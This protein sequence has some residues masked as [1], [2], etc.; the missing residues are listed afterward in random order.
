MLGPRTQEDIEACVCLYGFHKPG[1]SEPAVP[2]DGNFT[3]PVAT[4]DNEPD[5]LKASFGGSNCLKHH[6]F[7]IDAPIDGKNFGRRRQPCGESRSIPDN[8][9]DLSTLPDRQ[10]NRKAEV[11][12]AGTP[13][14]VS[15]ERS[16]FLCI[17]ESI[18]TLFN[19]LKRG[20]CGPL[21]RPAREQASP[22]ERSQSVQRLG[23]VVHR[24]TSGPDIPISAT[25]EGTGKIVHALCTASL[26]AKE[27]IDFEPDEQAVIVIVFATLVADPSLGP[28]G[29][30]NGILC[31]ICE[32][33][34]NAP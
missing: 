1:I 26:R 8:R 13:F 29:R 12:F 18:A 19:P 5:W 20:A 10:A 6:Q 11:H 15:K 4:A 31:R 25:E 3:N 21:G 28:S 17:N 22:V 9:I 33:A 27:R 2:I 16:W 7:R 30:N 32:I 34:P 23:D 24:E 14:L